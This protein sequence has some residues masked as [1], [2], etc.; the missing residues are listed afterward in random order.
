[1]LIVMRSLWARG[2]HALAEIISSLNEWN[3]LNL[4]GVS[5]LNVITF[6]S[7]SF[8]FPFCHLFPKTIWCS[9]VLQHHLCNGKIFEVTSGQQRGFQLF[10]VHWHW[11]HFLNWRNSICKK[12]NKK[13]KIETICCV[14]CKR[15][16]LYLLYW[17][18]VFI[19]RGVQSA[20]LCDMGKYQISAI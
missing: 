18:N 3:S 7:F 10:F 2:N 15:R 6:S 14:L 20:C 16:Q 19:K 4:S 11:S 8:F 1:M 17:P 5:V 12:K 9:N 13:I